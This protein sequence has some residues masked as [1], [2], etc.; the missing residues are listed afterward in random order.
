MVDPS[1]ESGPTLWVNPTAPGRAPENMDG[2]AAQ[3]V[4]ARHIWEEAV[5]T[6]HTFTSVQK[7]LK[8]QI[9]TVF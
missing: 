2:T 8:K 7:A 4:A 9:I 1:T 3:I 5:L 6:F